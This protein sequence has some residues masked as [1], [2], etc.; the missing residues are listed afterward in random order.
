MYRIIGADQ[1]EYGPISADQVRQWIVEGRINAQTKIQPE[2]S[3]DWKTVAEI[4]E[5]APHLPPRPVIPPAPISM[6]VGAVP[7]ARKNNPLAVWSVVVGVLSCCCGL[8]APV[9]IVLGVVALSQ[10]KNNPNQEGKGFAIG[11]LILGSLA[12]LLAII[13]VIM[14]IVSPNF[15]QNLQN[16]FPR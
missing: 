10:I 15:L 14:A 2:G 1:K 13:S 8:L 11:G 3:L 4:P 5:L 7:V 9:S 16:S 12:L 6:P